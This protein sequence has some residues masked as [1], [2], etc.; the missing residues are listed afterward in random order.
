MR[1]GCSLLLLSVPCLGAGQDYRMAR[2]TGETVNVRL[3]PGV[4][5]PAFGRLG[6]DAHA[7]ICGQEG[8]WYRVYLPRDFHVYLSDKD[9]TG[10]GKERVCV[11]DTTAR[12]W[13]DRAQMAVGTVAK[14]TKVR[15]IKQYG[16]WWAVEPPLCLTGFMKESF[17]EPV[18]EVPRE[19]VEALLGR[20]VVPLGP[21]PRTGDAGT[22]GTPTGDTAKGPG[23]ARPTKAVEPSGS[24]KGR[25]QPAARRVTGI[26]QKG[27]V[28]ITV[29]NYT[30]NINKVRTAF[31]KARKKPIDQWD[32]AEAKGA[33]RAVL[34]AKPTPEEK[35]FAETV[36]K[37]IG[38]LEHARGL[39]LPET[40][41][42]RVD[43]PP[44]IKK[45]QYLAVGWV[46]GQGRHMERVGTHVLEKGNK[47]LFYLTGE[48]VDLNACVNEMVAIQHGTVED[49]PPRFGCKLIRVK[50]L[51]V[52][53]APQ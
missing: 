23:V 31:L 20:E 16:V 48:D 49:L 1:L 32:F 26:P 30:E 29:R 35:Q 28:P 19:R 27:R 52:L 50:S 6:E 47:T 7:I 22:V 3:G 51:K 41:R 17:L 8:S 12:L 44:I 43:P 42:G 13:P 11:R 45:A 53:T 18:K 21:V 39:L 15:V 46:R 36:L 33:C 25:V 34:G 38:F 24:A 40:R 2:V 9:L 37:E 5:F 10:T 4:D 14:A